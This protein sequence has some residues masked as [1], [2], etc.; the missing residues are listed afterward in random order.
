MYTLKI[1]TQDMY[2]NVHKRR[3][4]HKRCTWIYVNLKKIDGDLLQKRGMR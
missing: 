4:R 3:V 1:S 2:I